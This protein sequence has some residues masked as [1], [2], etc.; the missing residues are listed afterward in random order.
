M[1]KISEF[2]PL[3]SLTGKE[4]I[5]LALDGK[6]FRIAVSALLELYGPNFKGVLTDPANL[7][8]VA[9]SKRGWIF[10][11]EGHLWMLGE[12]P[13][14]PGT[15]KWLDTGDYKGADGEK[16][17]DGAEGM[18]PNYSVN[19]GT[20][21][22]SQDDFQQEFNAQLTATKPE[23]AFGKRYLVP[24]DPADENERTMA[25]YTVFPTPLGRYIWGFGPNLL[26]NN[27][28]NASVVMYLPDGGT[29]NVLTMN[30]LQKGE[31][32]ETG[33]KGTDGK[34]GE[35]GKDG[36]DGTNGKNA[37]GM[38]VVGLLEE[39]Q[40]DQLPD[41][42]DFEIGDTYIVGKHFWMK[43]GV[44]WVDIGDFTGPDGNS[45]Y[46]VAVLNGFVGTEAE[47]L[48]SLKGADGIGLRIIG[49]L[50]NPN[51]LPEA[52]EASGDSY[53]IQEK[54]YVWDGTQW[55]TVGQVGPEGKPGEGI[56]QIAVRL[57]FTGTEA[58][59]IE[60]QRGPRGIQ[61]IQGIP[62]DP[63]K[64]GKDGKDG[65]N[66]SSVNFK[67]G[68]A[69]ESA[70]PATGNSVSDA[71][72]VE[73]VS[74]LFI[75]TGLAWYDTGVFSAKGEQGEQGKPGEDGEK[76]ETGP[77]GPSAYDV[78]VKDGFNGT[79]TQWLLSLIGKGLTAK[80]TVAT[81][82]DLANV[83]NPQQ[84]WAYN[85]LGGDKIG[86][87]YVYNGTQFVDMGDIR[88]QKGDQGIQGLKG[89]PGPSL[90]PKGSVADSADLLAITDA[91]IGWLYNVTGGDDAGHQFIWNGADWIDMGNI[92]GGVGL[93]GIQ[94]DPGEKGEDGKNAGG[95]NFKGVVSA[96]NQLP[97]A[98]NIN[99]DAYFV[100][101]NLFVW[102]DTQWVDCGSFQGLQG[103]KGDPGDKGETGEDG[104]DG[105]D[106]AAGKSTYQ[107]AVDQGYV[108]TEAQWLMTQV[109]APVQAKGEVADVAALNAVVNPKQGWLYNVTATGH[110]YIY[111]A[112]WVD[113]GLVRGIQGI[114]GIQGVQGNPGTDGKDGVDG[115]N[116]ENGKSLV[117]KGRV[118]TDADLPAAPEFG[119]AYFVGTE[120]KI[121]DGTEWVDFGD[122]EGPEGPQGIQGEMGAGIKILGTKASQGD[123]PTTGTIGDGYMI[124]TDFWV[125]D[126]T[127]YV[128]VGP[129]KGP[130]GDQGLRGLQGLKGEKGEPGDKGDKGDQGTLLIILDRDPGPLDGRIND[131]FMST[132]D[133]KLYRKTSD[134]AWAYMGT[135]GGG[136]VYD[137][138]HD[139]KKYVYLNG[140]WVALWIPDA[141]SLTDNN[142]YFLKNGAWDIFNAYDVKTM[143]VTD[144]VCDFTK[145]QWF[146]IDGTKAS[147][148]TFP[149][150]PAAASNRG[151]TLI[152]SF[153]GKGGNLAW[154]STMKWSG[155]SIPTFGDTKT[156]L[157][158]T[159]DG[160]TMIGS[161]SQSY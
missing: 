129:I 136:N 120:L 143:A 70:L 112:T 126:G 110:M 154:P 117:G 36:K 20:P 107:I 38:Q 147:T 95:V 99:A 32:G 68:V 118:E 31:K 18:L 67:G 114:Q 133:Q 60:S 153:T 52:G 81:F 125:W 96:Q 130:K 29:A 46:K 89:D 119:W 64:D 51:L 45:A 137:A 87:Q 69:T 57:G 9:D 7:P 86:H 25:G 6:N 101:Q 151:T 61:G 104:K 88:G 43:V 63:G 34:D 127:A 142:R 33:E 106:G 59:F 157:V 35:N 131:Y 73:D 74:H 121:Y 85:V 140:A 62:G 145:A 98:G 109:G 132:V 5:P 15:D 135:F 17:T 72:M 123:L 2:D 128:D 79:E 21:N 40:E 124:G 10:Q 144:G 13:Q 82:E 14:N 77:E 39:G 84:G 78:A 8:A 148:I 156:V 139:G 155:G 116:G 75:W 71:W 134:T 42:A 24:V 4:E 150:L 55:S 83:A 19:D 94:G 16:G 90:I 115:T 54:M 141:P 152:I 146:L 47:W 28:A 65:T 159:W 66:A 102:N 111:N 108:G 22:I 97:T 23:A 30:V 44:E 48:K 113:M 158:F 26:G 12:D 37:V 93:Q 92:R 41:P 1:A 3:S 56:Y 149:N 91:V 80:G 122:F 53:I 76:G 58:E 138:P 27:G 160:T 50:S 105:N 49:S 161:L 11:I 103:E 100:V